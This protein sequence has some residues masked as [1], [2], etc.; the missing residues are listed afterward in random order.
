MQII[1]PDVPRANHL[2]IGF[3]PDSAAAGIKQLCDMTVDGL[4]AGLRGGM[5]IP[6]WIG[7]MTTLHTHLV[8][9]LE[10]EDAGIQRNLVGGIISQHSETLRTLTYLTTVSNVSFEMFGCLQNLEDLTIVYPGHAMRFSEIRHNNPL[11]RRVQFPSLKRLHISNFDTQSLF[12]CDELRPI[13]PGL[14]HLRLSGRRCYP[15]LERLPVRTKVLIQPI[16]ILREEQQAQVSHIRRIL[17]KRSY[18]ERFT[19][20][21]PGFINYNAYGFIDGLVD[22]LDVSSGG[23]AFWN[24]ENEVT[25]DELA[26]R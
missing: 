21:E 25:I 4:K 16:L 2:C 22:W 17:S 3:V 1:P 24:A 15:N 10:E 19:L 26:A 14:T 20:L 23:N 8:Y 6:R 12:D 7:K 5:R 11:R 9:P 13:A 18:R